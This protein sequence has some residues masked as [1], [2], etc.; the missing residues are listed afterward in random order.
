MTRIVFEALHDGVEPPQRAT[1]GSAG[2]DLRAFLVQRTLTCSD[3]TKLWTVQTGEGTAAAVTLEPG[4]MAL[5]PLGFK[6]R[7]PDG[8]E[9]QV[10]PRSGASFKRGIVIPNAPGTIDADYPDE[11]MVPVRN[12]TA[13]P[14]R[15]EHGERIAQ[16][17]L[18]RYEVMNWATGTVAQT[19]DRAGGFGSTGH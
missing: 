5:V 16:V 3:G 2:Y 15:I 18:Q 17:I 10:R 4:Q 12:G 1:A 9:A 6:A 11:W 8:F 7:L 13:Q 19:T 14:L